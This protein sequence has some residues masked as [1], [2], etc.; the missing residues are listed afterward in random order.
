MVL[1]P[2]DRTQTLLLQHELNRQGVATQTA[3]TPQ[4]GI[5]LAKQTGASWVI[6]AP[7]RW[8]DPPQVQPTRSPL[9]PLDV[10]HVWGGGNDGGQGG[11]AAGMPLSQPQAP[12]AAYG[13]AT[14]SGYGHPPVPPSQGKLGGVRTFTDSMIDDGHWPVHVPLT[15]CLPIVLTT[16]VIGTPDTPSTHITE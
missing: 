13:A 14:W 9:K 8:A 3:A 11:G 16:S 15:L 10:P 7:G 5:T 1:V 12:Q 4:A 2:Q 6:G